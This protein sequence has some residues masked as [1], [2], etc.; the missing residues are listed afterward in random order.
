[1]PIVFSVTKAKQ[2][3]PEGTENE[4]AIGRETNSCY[5]LTG[6]GRELKLPNRK[7]DIQTEA[8]S[9]K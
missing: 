5:Q 9:S 8:T 3:P 6:V 4:A 1:M 7:E 2:K